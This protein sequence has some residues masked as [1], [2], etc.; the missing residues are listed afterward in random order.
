MSTVIAIGVGTVFLAAFLG[1]M[2]GFGYNLVSTPLLLLLGVEPASAVAINLAIAMVTRVAVVLRLGR[3]VRWRRA[4][5]MT[6]GSVPGLVL[7]AFVGGAIDPQGIRIVAG[8]LVL[9]VAPVLMVRKPKPGDKSPAR[10]AMAGFAGGALGT[11]T[12]LNGVPVALTLAADARDQRSFIADLA[13]YFVLS[14]IF[15]LVV[16]GLRDGVASADLVLLAWW[17]PGALVANWLGTRLGQ[18][19]RPDVFRVATCV[20][21]MAAGVATLVSA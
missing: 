21:V 3:Y 11:T 10:Y 17:L 18:R 20:L 5:P 15:G 2:T 9:V 1:G 19:I 4:L 6:A 16:L 7:G 14:N 8:V 12:S 13:V